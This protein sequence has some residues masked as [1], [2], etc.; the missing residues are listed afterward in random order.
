MGQFGYK[1]CN[2]KSGSIYDVMLGVRDNYDY[3]KAMLTNSLFTDFIAQNGLETHNGST[4][5]IID[6]DFVYGSVS[7]EQQV[8]RLKKRSEEAQ[9]DEEREKINRLLAKAEENKNKFDRK[10]AD[11]L[12]EIFYQ[13]GVDITYTSKRSQPV[14][15]HYKMLYRTPGKAKKGSCMFIREELYEKARDFLYMGIQLPEHN[16][17]IVEIGAYSS[18]ST[19]TIID[20]IQINPNDI[21]ILRDVESAFST[22]AISIETDEQKHCQAIRRENYEV[23]NTMFDG[24]ALID[25]S[26]FP[27]YGNGYILLRHHFTK[28]AAFATDIQR[29]F[30]DYFGDQYEMAVVR[31]MFGN[32]HYA[33]D[34]KLITTDQAVKWLKFDISYDYWCEKVH[35]N[36]CMFGVVKTAHP[37]KLGNVQR[38]SYQMVNALDQNTIDRVVEGSLRYIE[39]LKRDTETFINFLRHSSTF[40]NDYEV[41]V[42]LYEQ[43]HTFEQ[44]E[45]FRDRRQRIIREYVKDLKT[46]KIIQNGDN[47][48]IIGSPYAM[49]LHSV[50]A[51]VSEDPTFEQEEKAI[52][53]YT[54]RFEEGVYLAGFRNPYNSQNN[55]NC[56]H[57]VK[58]NIFTTYFRFCPQIIAVNMIHTDLQDRNNGSDQDSD[59]LYVTDQKDIVTHA[60]QCYKKYPT[61][62]NNIPKETNFY[63]SSM[64]SF[65]SVD[66]KLAAAQRAIG[67]SSNLAQI[68]LTYTY[69]FPDQK[70]VDYVCIL[71][72]L[73]QA[74]IDSAK[75]SFDIDIS[76]EIQR[77]K[78]DIN[79]KENK[80]P[81]FWLSIRQGFDRKKINTELTC[82][83]NYLYGVPVKKIQP[84]TPTLPMSTFFVK[85]DLDMSRKVSKRIEE[86]IE[87]YSLEFY[88]FVV[89]DVWDD[90]QKLFLIRNDFQD[91]IDD[92]KQ[93]GMPSKYIGLMSWLIN[94]AFMITSNI[95]SNK[96]ITNSKLNK[97][98]S[99]LLKVLYQVNP[100]ALLKCFAGNL[101]KSG[102]Q[103]NFDIKK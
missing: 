21:L 42:A 30:Q 43:D 65:A 51:D 94:R 41:L 49:L 57:N 47:L 101:P 33:R 60:M 76:E 44:S 96:L 29:F 56:L 97:N 90:N 67:E 100:E 32:K 25:L 62:V 48:V 22:T 95:R 1:I 19:S 4:R 26:I 83:M 18:L 27:E 16:A 81:A 53:C 54:E 64:T 87:R 10:S 91:L 46:G 89:D 6:I 52:Q 69:N 74:A 12:R 77:I 98:K 61:I 55:M 102:H 24:Q 34:I 8:A 11:E 68:C 85:Y 31:D 15:I 99:I 40:A 71:A 14:T 92:I 58:H 9:N 36:G 35:E 78:Q 5:D 79:L 80:Y 13:N 45:Y 73:A 39:Q 84:K 93:I 28:M 103:A 38:M 59:S 7:Y 3:N 50:G 37:S 66:N 2:F 70:Y 20:K 75:R 17:P 82:P 86:L 63:D 72:V 23:R 88:N